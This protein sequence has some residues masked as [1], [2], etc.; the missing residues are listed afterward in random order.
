MRYTPYAVLCL[1]VSLAAFAFADVGPAVLRTSALVALAAAFAF[2]LLDVLDTR[3]E[4]RADRRCPVCAARDDEPALDLVE[5]AAAPDVE[6]V[7]E[8]HASAEPGFTPSA[9]TYVGRATAVQR[10]TGELRAL[11]HLFVGPDLLT[12]RVADP[13]TGPMPRIDEPAMT[14]VRPYLDAP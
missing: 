11:D 4:V 12:H 10:A 7:V 13:T 8:V 1:A 6:P 5:P 9:D 3:A 2:C 14:R